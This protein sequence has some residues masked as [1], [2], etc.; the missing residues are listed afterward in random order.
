MSENNNSG[1]SIK[2]NRTTF[3]LDWDSRQWIYKF[4]Q[5]GPYYLTSLESVYSRLTDDLIR[6]KKSPLDVEELQKTLKMARGFI[7]ETNDKIGK[8]LDKKRKKLTK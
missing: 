7:K 6:F 3:R 4:G 1:I 5:S 8:V 2:I